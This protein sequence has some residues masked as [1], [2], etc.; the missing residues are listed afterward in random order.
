[1][2]DG[3]TKI[4]LHN[5]AAM[6]IMD[7]EQLKLDAE[8][9]A[10]IRRRV[11]E[12]VTDPVTAEALKPWYNQLCKRPCF[13]DEFLPAFNRPNV[14]LVDTAGRGVERITEDAV[15]VDGISYPVDCIVYASGFEVSG[16]HLHM[17]GFE[18]YGRAGVTLTDAWRE[19]PQTL[20]GIVARGFPNLLRFSM[21]QGGIAIN[22]A[23]ILGELSNHSAWFIRR[24]LDEGITEAEPTEEAQEAWFQTLLA[25]MG[26]LGMFYAQCTPSYMNGEGTKEANM[27][28]LRHIAFFGGTLE[29]MDLLRE[30]R[31]AGDF[32]GME[33]TR[34]A[35]MAG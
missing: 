33:L 16:S 23:H 8:N 35:I 21:T 34:A 22:F 30:W 27:A 10:A 26:S 29:Y 6:G 2:Q 17:L 14:K 18:I 28:A 24:C 32:P 12:T 9:M 7:E 15:V 11:E 20:H 31:D 3:W 5:P 1:V 13:H 25:N 19:G 4:F